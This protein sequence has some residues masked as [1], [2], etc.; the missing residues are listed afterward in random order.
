MRRC[1]PRWRPSIPTIPSA[2]FFEADGN[3]LIG[4]KAIDAYVEGVPGRL[5]R[6]LKSVLGTALIEETTRVGRER[7][8]FRDVIAY[9]SRRGEAARRA[10]DRAA[11]CATSGA[12]PPGAFRRQLAGRRSQGGGDA[13]H[14]RAARSASRKSRSSSSRSPRRWTTSARVQGEEIALIADIGG[15]TSDFSIV[16]LSPERHKQGRPQGRHSGQ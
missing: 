2:I 3:V 1:W 8:G 9:L 13:A 14:H 4:R 6:S 10:G 11:S 16:R 5:M 15:G 12:R 7:K